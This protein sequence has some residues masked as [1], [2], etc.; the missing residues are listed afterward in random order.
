[1]SFTRAKLE[2]IVEEAK[3]RGWID[4]GVFV[5]DRGRSYPYRYTLM[6]YLENSSEVTYDVG[7]WWPHSQGLGRY[8]KTPRALFHVMSVEMD[9]T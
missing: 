4:K 3:E 9:R 2:G 7:A 8:F 6:R 5:V 1:M